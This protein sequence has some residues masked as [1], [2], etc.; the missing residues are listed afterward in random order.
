M[1]QRVPTWFNENIAED[2]AYTAAIS[3][4][5]ANTNIDEWFMKEEKNMVSVSI[6]S[7]AVE[8]RFRVGH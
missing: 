6:L 7:I 5:P 1:T 4:Y 8:I 2:H 3:M